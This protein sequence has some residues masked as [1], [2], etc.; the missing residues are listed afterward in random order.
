MDDFLI[1][2]GD[3]T[4]G[5]DTMSLLDQMKI[6]L[7]KNL[8]SQLPDAPPIVGCQACYNSCSGSCGG[9]CSGSCQAANW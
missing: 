4:I 6:A 9:T 3:L 2:T 5:S 1:D 7:A 8:P